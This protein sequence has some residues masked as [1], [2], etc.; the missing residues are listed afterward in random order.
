M[1]I[2]AWCLFGVFCATPVH[3]HHHHHHRHHLRPH[4]LHVI[5]E[6]KVVVKP[7][8]I[9]PVVV[10][11]TVVKPAASPE[12]TPKPPRRPIFF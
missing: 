7:V 4:T 5:L 6:K 11:P 1:K 12:T 2:V 8:V 3:L 10:R 9:K